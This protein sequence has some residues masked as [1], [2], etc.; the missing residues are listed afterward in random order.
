MK[1]I[2][3]QKIDFLNGASTQSLDKVSKIS[4]Q[5]FYKKGVTILNQRQSTVT[6]LYVIQGWIKI[7]RESISGEEILVDIIGQHQSCGE[8]FLFDRDINDTYTV[9][10]ISNIEIITIPI[11]KLKNIMLTDNMLTLSILEKALQKQRRF[12]MDFEH[13]LIQNAAQRIGCFLLRLCDQTNNTDITLRLPYDKVL[14]ASHLNMRA[15]TFSRALIKLTTQCGLVLKKE[16]IYIPNLNTLS[17]YI[18]LHC[19]KTFPCKA[20]HPTIP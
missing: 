16:G 19:S 4:K 7:F 18:C 3:L 12:Y 13:L 6:F 11:H 9:Q 8:P 17:Q 2:Y 20:T 14:L 10:S 15:E 1:T 5:H